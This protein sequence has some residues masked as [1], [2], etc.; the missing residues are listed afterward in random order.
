MARPFLCRLGLAQISFNPAYADELMSCI[1]EPTFPA[2]NEKTGLFSISGLDEIGHLQQNLGEKYVA[3]L[4]RKVE[5]IVRFASG[6]GVELLVFPEYS[7]P[8]ETLPLCHALSEELGIA[9]IAGSHVITLSESAQQT[10]RDLGLVF[11]EGNKPTEERIR[12]AAC[13]VFVPKQKPVGFVKYLRSKWE[14]YLSKGSKTFHAFEMNTKRGRIEV[15]VLICIEALASRQS[16]EKHSL[17]RLVAITAFTPKADHFHDEGRRNLLKGKCTLFANVAEFGGSRVFARADTT[18]LWFTEKDGSKAIPKGSEALLVIEADLEKQFEVRQ[19]MTEQTAVTD[20]RIFPILYAA[21]SL[22]SRQFTEIRDLALAT[23]PTLAELSS[24]VAPFITLN[25]RVFPKLLQEKLSHFVGHLAPAG[26]ISIKEA[27]EWIAP[28]VVPDIHSTNV[29][30]WELCNQSMEAVNSLLVSGKYVHKTKELM[31]VYT[32]LL[33]SRNELAGTIPLRTDDASRSPQV[34]PAAQEASSKSPFIDRDQ[35]FDKIRQ[36]F[37]QQ[38]SSVL[39]LGG[40]RGIGKSALTHEAFRQAIPPRKRIWLQLTEGTS[41]LRLLAELAYEC[42]LQLPENLNLSNPATQTEVKKRVLAYLGQGPGAVVVLD[43]FQLL[44]NSS[45]EVEDPAIRALLLELAEAGQRGKTKYF[46]ISHVFPRLSPSFENCIISF[47]LHGLDAAD[48]RRLLDKWV[49][50]ERDDLAGQ[51]GSASEKL[52]SILGGHPLAIK[53]A[54]RLWANHPTANIVEEFSIFKELRD[55]IVVFLLEKLTVSAAE[56]ELLSFASIFRVPAPR[57]V[58][59]N[60]RKEDASVLLSSVAGNYLIE[61]SDRGYQLHPLV[62]S[63][64]GNGLPL[65]QVKA[66]HKVAAKF[67]LQEFERLKT[68]SNQIVP[69]YLGEAVHHF[70]AAG[71]RQKVQDFAFYGQELRPVALEHFRNG[72]HKVALK[73]YEVLLE[74]DK[75]DVDAHFHLSLIFAGM[76]RWSDAELH[77]GKAISLKPKA[78]WIL[79]GFAK[80]KLRAGKWAEG[81]ALLLEAEKINPNHSATL[82]ELGRLREKQ[83][84]F[85]EAYEYYN[86]AIAADR[87]NSYAYYLLSRLLYRDGDIKEAFQMAKTALVGN[88]LSARNK[89]LVQ[90]LK[91]KVAEA[92][93]N[94]KQGVRTLVKIRCVEKS[95]GPA[96]HERI[97]AIGGMNSDGKR[98]KIKLADAIVQVESGKYIFYIEDTAAQKVELAIATDASGHKYLKTVHD[99]EQPESMLSLPACP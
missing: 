89:A 13:I 98:W 76:A 3:N 37:N 6:H 56:R 24:Q 71:E 17:P 61:S 93:G 94:L 19:L 73:D 25:A 53:L 42:N 20:V 68:S 96:P 39:I 69:E 36:F 27:I 77:F 91:N 75:N 48:T 82:V 1:Q 32:H 74:L 65:E 46:F 70:L 60:W 30:R 29:L 57:E 86:R 63:Y 12:E 99:K 10:Y 78:P 28:I 2:E 80:A 95:S 90:D 45:A 33:S 22:E 4:N 15:Q 62:R 5:S 79:Q 67:Y 18:S 31:E 85:S 97:E 23:N 55:T 11:E 88:P 8:P 41:Y 81:E 14:A 9:L 44:L 87:N 59:L 52:I 92:A 40:M 16:K 21:D 49:Q 54:A 38:Q 51:L 7:I 34:K 58:F 64:F 84:Q 26:T 83:K 43:E 72:E 35:A 47:T 66:W 50:F